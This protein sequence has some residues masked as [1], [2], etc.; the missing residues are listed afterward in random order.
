MTSEQ[1]EQLKAMPLIE[2]TKKY[3]P[4]VL[5]GDITREQYEW[6]M[7]LN[8]PATYTQEEAV[9]ALGGDLSP[10]THH[11]D[12]IVGKSQKERLYSLLRDGAWHDTVE[13]LEK[14]YGGNR[15]GIARVGARIH[16]LRQDG[17]TIEGR[18]KT[19]TIYEY[20]LIHP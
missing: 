6:I 20:R 17:H 3:T 5:K 13:I 4:L 19:K 14:V 7:S 15:S 12:K 9:N 1:L 8:A 10:T 11:T 2:R 16:D 18:D